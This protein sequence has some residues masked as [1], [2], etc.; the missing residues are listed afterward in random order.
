MHNVV[1]ITTATAEISIEPRNMTCAVCNE[2]WVETFPDKSGDYEVG[3]IKRY[4]CACERE[5]K[6]LFDS[7][8]SVVNVQNAVKYNRSLGFFDPAYRRYTFKADDRKNPEISDLC[9]SYV[10]QWETMSAENLG[11][12]FTGPSST[13]KTFYACCIANAVLENKIVDFT[14]RGQIM[15]SDEVIVATFPMLIA[16]LS[17]AKFNQKEQLL[18][19]LAKS[20]LFVIDELGVERQSEYM[21]EQVYTIIDARARSGKPLIITT[22]LT[23]D[24]LI[25]PEYV[26]HSRIYDRILEMC[27]GIIIPVNGDSRRQDIAASKREKAGI[28]L[29]SI[30]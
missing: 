2:K 28:L 25:N 20:A 26:E 13:G 8:E 1:S 15:P 9:L 11:I 19:D 23:P 29:G 16:K 14:R 21:L 30:S 24:E 12:L 4:L 17:A 3:K 5:R 18:D 10:N 6:Q 27:G 22:N 7:M